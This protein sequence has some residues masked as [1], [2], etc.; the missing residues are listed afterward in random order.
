MSMS[1]EEIEALMNGADDFSEEE[2]D[3]N[4]DSSDN[5]D[6]ILAG[7]D[8]ISEDESSTEEE[9]FDDILAGID[10]ITGAEEDNYDDI[11]AGIDGVVDEPEKAK[12]KPQEVM[13]ESKYPLPVQKEHKVV[14]QLNE[15]AKD[16]EL[17]AS[18]IFD[19]LSFV[20]DENN[21]I[22]NYNKQMGEF[23]LKQTELLNS[24]SDKFPNVNLFK[25]NLDSANS[26]MSASKELAAKVDAEN[27][28]IF[29]AMELMQYHDINRQK[30]ERVMSV[31]RKLSDYLN[32]IFEDDAVGPKVQIAKH[33]SG[34]SSDT[35]ADDDMD[36]LIAEFAN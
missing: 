20:L 4:S 18:Q 7:I 10:G 2:S 24:L 15:V 25:E 31:I 11:L 35:I 19:V 28:K 5:F 34:D 32:G 16:S 36:A 13:D 8:G 9:N 3:T 6:D 27:M 12:S 33:I 26:V 1:Q 17:K 23:V 30:I 21:E 29:E 22:Q 14:N